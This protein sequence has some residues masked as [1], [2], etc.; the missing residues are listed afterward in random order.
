MS[1]TIALYARSKQW[2]LESVTIRLRHTRI[3]AKDCAD[4]LNGKDAYLERI[5]TAVKLEGGL[6]AEQR[7]KLLEIGHKCPVHRSLKADI[8]ITEVT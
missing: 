8:V 3:H 1:M 6:T 5:E 4:C 2:P 7:S